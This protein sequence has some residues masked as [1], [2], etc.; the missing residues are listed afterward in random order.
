MLNFK[1]IEIFNGKSQICDMTAI[2]GA[3][4]RSVF[5]GN[6]ILLKIREENNGHRYID[7][8][9]KKVCFFSNLS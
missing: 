5:D 2:S 3:F 4:D 1:P 8:G 9:G 7:I 6:T